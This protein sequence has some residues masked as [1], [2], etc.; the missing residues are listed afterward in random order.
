ML[1][2]NHT[3]SENFF[4]EI[5]SYKKEVHMLDRLKRIIKRN[6]IAS[7]AAELNY[8]SETTIR[9]WIESNR[10]PPIAHEK[11]KEYL[12]GR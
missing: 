11:V 9:K 4:Q 8:K 1:D 3:V 2:Q 5:F 6:G 10:I 7:V 12:K